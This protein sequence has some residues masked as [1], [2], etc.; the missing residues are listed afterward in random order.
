MMSTLADNDEAQRE[1]ILACS[2]HKRSTEAKAC[3][4]AFLIRQCPRPLM[5]R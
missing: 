4:I 3:P 5:F 2:L 1:S